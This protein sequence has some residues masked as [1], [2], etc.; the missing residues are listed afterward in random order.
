MSHWAAVLAGG[1]GTRF[2]P[3]STASRPKQLLPLTGNAPLLVQAVARLAGL[4]PPERTLVLTGAPLVASVRALLPDVPSEN[5]L[6]EP[7][8]AST[9]PALTWATTVAAF[10]DPAA[11]VLSLHADWYVGDDAAF[12]LSAGRALEVAQRHDVLVTVGVVPTRPDPGYGYILPG[13]ALEGDAREVTRFV[14]KPEPARAAELI[15]EGALW[16]SGLFA[17]TAA[18][19][20][21]ETRAAAREIAPHVALLA[22]GDVAGFFAAVT[23]VAVDVSHFERSTRVAVVPGRFPWDDVGTWGAL[24]RVRST[25]AAGNV[26]VGRA[27]ARASGDC[28][29]WSEERPVVVDGVRD[30]VVVHAN[31]VTLVTT[32]QRAADLKDLL[33]SL[34]AQWREMSS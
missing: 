10:R 9:A 7:R 32:R 15:A 28:I 24:S 8:A 1:S 14:E 29:V 11:T 13:A 20:L 2:W 23:P 12:R 31:G 34:P 18:R 27:L 30:L 33:A 6:G 17:W 19:F 3:L 16:N 4:I 26:L 22:G 5:V 21:E 25:D